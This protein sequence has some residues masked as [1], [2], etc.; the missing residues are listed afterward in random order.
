MYWYTYHRI[1]SVKTDGDFCVFAACAVDLSKAWRDLWYL[2]PRSLRRDRTESTPF[3]YT[4]MGPDLKIA[5]QLQP[6]WW[7]TYVLNLS[8]SHFFGWFDDLFLG[9]WVWNTD[10]Q[11]GHPPWEGAL[12]V[13]PSGSPVAILTSKPQT[14]LSLDLFGYPHI[15][16]PYQ[17]PYQYPSIPMWFC[18]LNY[19]E[20]TCAFGCGKAPAAPAWHFPSAPRCSIPLWI[21]RSQCAEL[22]FSADS[23]CFSQSHI[24]KWI[25]VLRIGPFDGSSHDKITKW[26]ESGSFMKFSPS[27]VSCL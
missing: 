4:E 12:K 27:F 13:T 8:T 20:R 2:L 9:F 23:F 14:S 17:Y 1:C 25:S 6:F 18:I 19:C 26:L 3:G 5:I 22:R 24:K 11:L 16:D 15:Y 7:F 10:V 21:G